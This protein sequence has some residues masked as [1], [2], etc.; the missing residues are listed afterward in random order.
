M[1]RRKIFESSELCFTL[2]KRKGL[3]FGFIEVGRT[4]YRTLVLQTL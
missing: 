2:E 1:R 4:I 3:L